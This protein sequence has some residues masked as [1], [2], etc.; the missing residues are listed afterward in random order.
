[1]LKYPPAQALFLAAGQEIAGDASVGVW[2]STV[3]ASIGIY[4]ALLPWLPAGRGLLGGLW[5][6]THLGVSYWNHSYWGGSVAAFAG[7]LVLGSVLRMLS[8]VKARYAVTLGVGLGL[9]ALSRPY[10]G[11]LVAM[12]IGSVLLVWIFSSDAPPTGLVIRQLLLPCAGALLPF[13]LAL[14]FY[15]WRTTGKVTVMPYQVYTRQY[16]RVPYFVFRDLLK[17][18]VDHPRWIRALDDAPDQDYWPKRSAQGFTAASLDA[19][20]K[21]TRFY[22]PPNS[23]LHPWRCRSW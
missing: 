1:M 11:F 9:L 5:A 22:L 16:Q 10:E 14:C 19:I 17:P 20:W 18:S 2:L 13:A 3:L 7:G 6:A 12:V 21:A 4:W 8:G 15:N 23:C